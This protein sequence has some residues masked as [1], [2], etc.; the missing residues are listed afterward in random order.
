MQPMQSKGSGRDSA[1]RRRRT[2]EAFLLLAAYYFL[3]FVVGF[4]DGICPDFATPL[5]RVASRRHRNRGDTRGTSFL[6]ARRSKPQRAPRL[7]DLHLEPCCQHVPN[8]AA[9]TW[10]SAVPVSWSSLVI[11]EQNLS[12]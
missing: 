11:F 4:Q 3:R 9:D 10:L 12:A 8:F 1:S 7:P 5:P 2:A 6:H